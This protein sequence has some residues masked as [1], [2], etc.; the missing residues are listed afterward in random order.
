[1]VGKSKNKAKDNTI[2]GGWSIQHSDHR[3]ALSSLFSFK[4]EQDAKE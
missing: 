4:E 2:Q 1:M 3:L